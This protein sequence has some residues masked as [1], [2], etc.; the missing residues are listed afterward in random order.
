MKDDSIYL[1]HILECIGQIGEYTIDG[2]EEFIKSR[3][4]Q[5]AVIRNIEIIGEAA[6]CVSVDLREKYPEIPWKEMAGMHDILIHDYMG[7]DIG[8]VWN[9]V[10]HN[11]PEIKTHLLKILP[12]DLA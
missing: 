4:I 7:V 5:D 11:L 2:R 12:P 3:L 6:K 10:S 8:I 9:V 1:V